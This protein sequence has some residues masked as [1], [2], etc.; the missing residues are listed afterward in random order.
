MDRIKLTIPF[1]P[2]LCQRLER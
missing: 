2:G 1:V